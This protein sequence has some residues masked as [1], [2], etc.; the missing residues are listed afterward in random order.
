EKQ[1]LLE[2]YAAAAQSDAL[3]AWPENESQTAERLYARTRVN[4]ISVTG[5]S[6]IAGRNA[7]GETGLT[8]VATCNLADGGKLLV[9]L[10]WSRAP[11]ATGW[12]GGEVTG[13][14]APGPRLVADPPLAGLEANA[15]PDPRDMPDNHFT[16]AVQW[17]LFA[18]VALVI[19]AMA[20]RN[21]LRSQ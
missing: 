9:A 10:G 21:R 12:Q 4:C 2:R 13:I 7:A 15:R 14:I 20:V 11:V 1:A 8:Q 3:V 18:L 6:A 19:Y 17:F 16:Y 5:R